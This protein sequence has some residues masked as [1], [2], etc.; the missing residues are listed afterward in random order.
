MENE[1]GNTIRHYRLKTGMS[2]E[3]LAMAAGGRNV[4]QINAYE[5]GRSRPSPR[6]LAEIAMALGVT[7]DDLLGR[8]EVS[9][10][11][12]NLAN[13]LGEFKRRLSELTGLPDTRFKISIDVG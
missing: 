5:R 2:Q 6:V 3:K 12:Q 4:T 1:I 10:A 11:T 13:L 8:H 7:S 9:Q